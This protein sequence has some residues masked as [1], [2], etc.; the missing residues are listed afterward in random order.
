MMETQKLYVIVQHDYINGG[1]LQYAIDG[2][3]FKSEKLANEYRKIKPDYEFTSV[4]E[5]MVYPNEN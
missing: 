5:L 2:L 4:E 3:L 1:Y